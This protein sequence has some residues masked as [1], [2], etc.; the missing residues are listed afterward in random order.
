MNVNSRITSL[1]S[2]LDRVQAQ[3]SELRMSLKSRKASA[4][5]SNTL[6]SRQNHALERTD[7]WLQKKRSELENKHQ[8]NLTKVENLSKETKRKKDNWTQDHSSLLHQSQDVRIEL[9]GL[10]DSIEKLAAQIGT[11]FPSFSN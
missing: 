8:E 10:L 4:S 3:T 2:E 6:T 11:I 9:T 1:E 5:S 7:M